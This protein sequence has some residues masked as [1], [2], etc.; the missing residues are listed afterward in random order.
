MLFFRL[1]Q[2]NYTLATQYH[3]IKIIKGTVNF[4]NPGQT[5]IDTFD[6]PVYALT[7][8][9]QQRFPIDLVQILTLGLF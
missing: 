1:Y 8:E 7:K 3:C 4:I 6:Q 9:I 5:P 2:R